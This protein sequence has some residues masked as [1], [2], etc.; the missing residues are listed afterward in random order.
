MS[1]FHIFGSIY[2][3]LNDH[4][5]LGKFDVKSNIDVFLGYSTNSKAYRIYNMRTQTIME[6]VN[7]V[8]DDSCDFSEFSNEENISGL[9]E[10]IGDEI[11]TDQSVVTPSKTGSGPNKSVATATTP[12]TG[13]VKPVATETIQEVDSRKSKGKSMN[14]LI[15]PIRKEPSSRIKKNHPSDLIIGD[16]NE[17][18][19]TRKKFIN[20]IKYVCFVSLY[21]LKNVKEIILDEFWIKAM[22]EEL[23]QF[24]RNNV[25][26]L[27]HRPKNTNVIGTK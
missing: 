15:D 7:V 21:E 18:M 10:E 23:E 26:N 9:I 24:S 3:I 2:Y 1:Y 13:I 16:P 5:H 25:W 14:V 27:V 8:I 22:H 19:V 11:A 12:E 4:E 6:S 20:H 17:G